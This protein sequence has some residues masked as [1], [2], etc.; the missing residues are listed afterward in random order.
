[1]QEVAKVNIILPAQ[2]TFDRPVQLVKKNLIVHDSRLWG[3]K[4]DD[5]FYHKKDV[6]LWNIIH[7]FYHSCVFM[8]QLDSSLGEPQTLQGH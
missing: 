2:S 4:E 8:E 1:M 3:I 7:I 6:Y 5:I